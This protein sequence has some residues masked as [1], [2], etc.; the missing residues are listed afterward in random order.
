VLKFL[1]FHEERYL[2]LSRDLFME[3]SQNLALLDDTFLVFFFE[4]FIHTQSVGLWSMRYT[5]KDILGLWVDIQR[6]L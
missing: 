2:K 6:G 1:Y 3:V 4:I 5:Q